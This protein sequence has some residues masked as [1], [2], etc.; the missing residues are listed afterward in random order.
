M[1]SIER[2]VGAQYF[3]LLVKQTLPKLPNL[4]KAVCNP[5]NV[6]YRNFVIYV[7]NMTLNFPQSRISSTPCCHLLFLFVATVKFRHYLLPTKNYGIYGQNVKRLLSYSGPT[8]NCCHIWMQ[9]NM[10][11]DRMARLPYSGPV[12]NCYKLWSLKYMHTDRIGNHSFY[13]V[14]YDVITIALVIPILI[15]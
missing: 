4:S 3:F 6:K 11:N 2:A 12:R 7:C 15:Q 14:I 9:T 10:H 5:L 13:V 1:K 8:R